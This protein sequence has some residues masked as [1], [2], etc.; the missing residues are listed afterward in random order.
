MCLLRQKV[1]K[2]E[3][4]YHNSNF[5]FDS[6]FETRFHLLDLDVTLKKNMNINGKSYEME[7]QKFI[8]IER[9]KSLFICKRTMVL[10]QLF[11]PS[12]RFEETRNRN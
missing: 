4:Y 12:P 8:K 6:D 9:N 10:Y 2:W 11:Q 5:K 1:I 3:G 7:N